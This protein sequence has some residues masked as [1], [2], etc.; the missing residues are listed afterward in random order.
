M[1]F[2]QGFTRKLKWTGKISWIYCLFGQQMEFYSIERT[3]AGVDFAGLNYFQIPPQTA[4]TVSSQRYQ[5]LW[6]RTRLRLVSKTHRCQ[7]SRSKETFRPLPQDNRRDGQNQRDQSTRQLWAN[8][9]Y[10]KYAVVVEQLN[11]KQSMEIGTKTNRFNRFHDGN[12][13]N[14]REKGKKEFR[15]I[16]TFI[17]GPNFFVCQMQRLNTRYWM[18]WAKHRNVSQSRYQRWH[19]LRQWVGAK[20]AKGARLLVSYFHL[21]LHAV[22]DLLRFGDLLLLLHNFR[23]VWT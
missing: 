20:F 18:A 3:L 23:C 15:F 1:P 11:T 12:S 4:D 14:D 8:E 10:R 5:S 13:V 2:G 9:F 22:R 17:C 7:L 6:H 21:Y 19:N 16:L